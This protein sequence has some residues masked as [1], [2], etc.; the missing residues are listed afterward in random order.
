[1]KRIIKVTMILLICFVFSGCK[2]KYN[3]ITYT[4]FNETFKNKTDYITNNLT[5][6]YEDRFERCLEAAGKNNQFLFYEFK[7]EEEYLLQRR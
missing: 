2:S 4:K 7:T 3:A 1:M 6:K 5:I